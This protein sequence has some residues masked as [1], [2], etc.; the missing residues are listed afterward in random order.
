MTNPICPSIVGKVALSV[1]SLP[2]PG[3]WRKASELLDASES[4]SVCYQATLSF[5][6]VHCYSTQ[7][8][9]TVCLFEIDS[10]HAASEDSSF[11]MWRECSSNFFPWVLADCSL[12]VQGR[13]T[14]W[15]FSKA[16]SEVTH[17]WLHDTV[18]PELIVGYCAHGNG[19]CPIL[20]PLF[21]LVKWVTI[22]SATTSLTLHLDTSWDGWT[23]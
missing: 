11:L 20:L 3:S 9:P 22:S 2:S 16:E 17:R 1:P 4:N 12:S 15:P 5:A 18:C 7:R 19:K 13:D 23:G 10:V 14:R 6:D 21:S 8:K